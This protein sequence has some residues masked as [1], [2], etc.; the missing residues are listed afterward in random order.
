MAIAGQFLITNRLIKKFGLS[1]T[2][3]SIPLLLAFGFLIISYN[4]SLLLI[5]VIIIIHRAGNFFLLKPSREILF[6][7]C[8]K[9]EKYRAKNFIDTVVYRGGDAITGWF[10]TLCISLG[11]GLSAIAILA[12]PLALIW[13]FI[14]YKLGKKQVVKEKEL[15]LNNFNYDK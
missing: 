5:A 7:V 10:F 11:F 3:C 1:V 12:I 13:S 6:T 15:I 8:R 4:V 9:D 14:G 2:L